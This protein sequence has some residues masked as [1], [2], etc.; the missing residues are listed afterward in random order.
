MSSSQRYDRRAVFA[1]AMYD[2]ANSSYA[3]L[4]LTFIF[5]AYFA[6]QI[7]LNKNVGTT[8]WTR[9]LATAAIIVAL[10]SPLLGAL[11]DRGGFRKR[12]LFIVTVVCVLCTGSLYFALPGQVEKALIFFVISSIAMELG[13]V[14]YNAFLPDVAPQEKIGR[15][16][17]YGW[18]LGYFGGLL[19][20][21]LAL[22]GFVYPENPWFG[23]S[24]EAGEN[25]RATNML[26]AVWFAVFSI[27]IF[28]W[29]NERVP[30]NRTSFGRLFLSSYQQLRDTFHEIRRYRQ[31]VRLLIARIFY[32]DGI[33]TLYSLGGIIAKTVFDFSFT[34]LM[35]LGIVLNITAGLGAFTLGFLDDRIGGKK[36]IQITNLAFILSTLIVVFA[37]SKLIFWGASLI[38][39]FFLGPNQA[40]SRSLMGRFLPEDKETEFFGFFAFSGKA[41][42]FMGPLLVGEVNRIFSSQRAGIAMVILFFVVGGLILNRVDEDEGKRLSGRAENIKPK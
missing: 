15:I 24:K 34:E 39:G 16:S 28:I 30:E 25:I 17:G 27:P 6:D 37:H 5:S 33:V 20:M 26:V 10:S 41:T 32:N 18:A 2:F 21:T 19:A 38:T 1:W 3:A 40:A 36:T 9:A 42:A 31:I 4:V 23:F 35:V 8:Q 14:F 13:M 22:F 7:A 12:I 29:V 11:A